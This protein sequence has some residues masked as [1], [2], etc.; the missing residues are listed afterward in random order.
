MA[1]FEN[2]LFCVVQFANWKVEAVPTQWLKNGQDGEVCCKCPTNTD[3]FEVLNYLFCVVQFANWKVEAVPTQWLKNGQDGEVCCKCPTNTDD[4]EVLVRNRS[5]PEDNWCEYNCSVLK[6]YNTLLEARRKIREIKN[7][8]NNPIIVNVASQNDN[9]EELTDPLDTKNFI[10]LSDARD[11]EMKET[12]QKILN[13]VE[14]L[15]EKINALETKQNL[16][17]TKIDELKI[18]YETLT[19]TPATHVRIDA[20]VL[21]CFPLTSIEEIHD[22]EKELQS[23][24]MV[25]KYVQHL[26][27]YVC[28]RSDKSIRQC[29]NSIYS[30]ELAKH[31]AWTNAKGNF[32]IKNLHQIRLIEG[33]VRKFHGC[34]SKEEFRVHTA[35]WFRR[36]DLRC[37]YEKECH[38]KAYEVLEVDL[39]NFIDNEVLMPLDV[40]VVC[41]DDDSGVANT[42]KTNKVTYHN[43]CQALFR[44]SMLQQ[45][46]K[47][48]EM[49]SANVG[50]ACIYYEKYKEE[51]DE[52]I[53]RVSSANCRKN[54]FK[55]V[56][57]SQNWVVHAQLNTAS[58]AED[59]QVSDIYYHASCYTKLKTEAC[60]ATMSSRSTFHQQ[61]YD[62][63]IIAQ[64]LASAKCNN[65]PQKV[66][67]TKKW[68]VN[69]L[70]TKK[71]GGYVHKFTLPSSKNTC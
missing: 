13:V 20:E 30:R 22:F 17:L 19:K 66:S 39:N 23:D 54:L 31:C 46:L 62:P 64:L 29:L 43:G 50:P 4:F 1:D 56:L 63:L 36:S 61:T 45:Q 28:D 60:A 57:Q 37:P 68:Y 8:L 65:S 5:P 58:D 16:M 26:K 47:E 42:M 3:D 14:G 35:N 67:Q 15:S 69:R 18:V 7:T 44:S 32:S 59:A 34:L 6:Y 2:Y 24:E 21:E 40:N 25:Q 53:Y 38:H 11:G 70:E 55:W 12:L 9:S 71:S 48:R 27:L 49:D 41:L 33:F 10:V 52:Q 51:D